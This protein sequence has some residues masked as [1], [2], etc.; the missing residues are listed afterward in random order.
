[1]YNHPRKSMIT[2]KACVW[3]Q[4][5]ITRRLQQHKKTA[6]CRT[7]HDKADNVITQVVVEV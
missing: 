5:R 2:H 3:G 7:Q 1:M 6:G 4:T